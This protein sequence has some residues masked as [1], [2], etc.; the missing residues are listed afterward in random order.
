MVLASVDLRR[1]F[2]IYLL[3]GQTA[4]YGVG[5]A[6]TEEFV[7]LGRDQVARGIGQSAELHTG[8]HHPRRNAY[9]S[10]TV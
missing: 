9:G 5:A 8:Q 1:V 4:S 7:T 3:K 6:E 2:I 10:Q